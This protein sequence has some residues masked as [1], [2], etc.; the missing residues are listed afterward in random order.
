MGTCEPGQGRNPAAIS[1]Q[2][3]V[4]WVSHRRP[5]RAVAHVR[6]DAIGHDR[7]VSTCR[8]PPLRTS[9][10]TARSRG[11]YVVVA[12]RY[13]PQTFAE[14]VGQEHVAKALAGAIAAEPR[15]PRLSVH[16]RP[17]R[18]Q[19]VGRPDPGQGAEL[20][21]RPDAH[22][23]QPVRHLP[24]HQ[25]RATTSTCWRSTA[26]A[27]AAST[28]SAS[29]GRT[30]NVRPSRV[31]LQDLHHRRSSHADARGVQRLAQ[32][33]GRAAG[34]CEVHLLHDRAGKDSDHDP[35]ALPAVRFR[36][37]P[38]AV[39]RRAAAADRRQPKG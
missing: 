25:R 16:R 1:S 24:E 31:A 5:T 9:P 21:A 37:H 23:L 38:D 12:R 22:A 7:A 19:D 4:R 34:A 29:C 18:R 8:A 17:R 11:E 2:P 30:S 13:R 6:Y 14:L 3:F 15:R 10:A 36:R 26:P 35:V 39:D 20:R 33:A 32:D 27:T 28:K